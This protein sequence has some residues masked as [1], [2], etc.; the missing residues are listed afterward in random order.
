MPILPRA[1]SLALVALVAGGARA[2]DLADVPASSPDQNQRPPVT[3]SLHAFTAYEFEADT[4]DGDASYSVF[5]AGGD[6]TIGWRA[7][8]ALNLSFGIGYDVSDYSFDNF[9][10]IVPAIDEDDPF[11]EFHQFSFSVTGRYQLD[12]TWHV[13][14][15]GFARAGFETGADVGDSWTGGGFGAVG[16][17][18]GEDLTLGFGVGATSQHDDDP[19]VF[20]VITVNWQIN[21]K[22]RLDSQKLGARLTYTLTDELDLFARAEYFRREYRLDEH[23]DIDSG[24]FRDARVPVGVG[25][26]WRPLAGLTVGFEAGAMVYS[27]LRFYDDDNDRVASTDADPTAYLALHLS[28]TF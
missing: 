10:D 18:V 4:D 28:Y 15:G 16:F 17:R 7:S 19:F 6:A 21:E 1:I 11:D 24:V 26:E 23:E 2:Q 22:L 25:V 9:S 8:E 5:R 3:L 20:P 14:L 13:S 12:P 27:E